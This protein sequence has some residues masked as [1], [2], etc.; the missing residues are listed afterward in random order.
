VWTLAEQGN[1]SFIDTAGLSVIENST[2]TPI[3]VT[4]DRIASL[5]WGSGA[6]AFCM[7]DPADWT[8]LSDV[9]PGQLL[10]VFGNNLDPQQTVLFNGSPAAILYSSQQQINV[11]APVEL[12]DQTAVTITVIAGNRSFSLP[13]SVV[14]SSPAAF[15]SAVSFAVDNPGLSCGNVAIL[16]AFPPLA[17]NDDGTYNGCAHSAPAG[18]RVTLYFNGA[19][20]HP[21]FSLPGSNSFVDIESAQVVPGFPAGFWRLKLRVSDRASGL[22]TVSA[23]IDGKSLRVAPLGLVFGN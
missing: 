14:Q 9:A 3:V 19:G 22:G 8:L 16:P 17:D 21:S 11:Q 5:T 10:T 18:S 6:D 4:S 2:G 20:L 1:R 7:L 13:L 15:L 12:A 23:Q